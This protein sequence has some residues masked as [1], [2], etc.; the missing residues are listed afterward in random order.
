[1]RPLL[2]AMAGNEPMAR[3]LA[4]SLEAEVGTLEQR[5]FPDGESYVRVGSSVTG[6]DVILV[7]TLDRPDSKCLP[8]LFAADAARDLGAKRVLLAAPYLGYLR[9]DRRFQEGEALTS[10]TFAALI[11]GHFN[12]L[13]TVDPHLHRY[14]SLDAVYRVPSKAVTAAP[15]LAGW[16][17]SNVSAPFLV[18]PDSESEQWVS[19]VARGSDAPFVVLSKT[20]KGDRDVEIALPGVDRY[21][22]RTPVIV[23]DI[24]START[25]IQTVGVLK[26]AGMRAPVCLG[27]HA[28]FA[29]QAYDD[30]ARSG[31]ERIVT[32]NTV[33][34]L[35]NGIDVSGV[36]S[37]AI[38]GLFLG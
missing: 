33:S 16:I 30:L 19:A 3:S 20:R 31:V 38:R 35:T 18:G 28:I 5:T 8:L 14:P 25:M 1:M 37:Q 29:D 32:C 23:D 7:A 27:V 13:V 11:S 34:H 17:R 4:G 2:L 22:E 6:R 9:Q 26:E 12:G 24:I 36:L 15:L 21:K 10:A